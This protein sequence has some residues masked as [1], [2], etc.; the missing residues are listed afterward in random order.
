MPTLW[1][2]LPTPAA[3]LLRSTQPISA[4]S[5]RNLD[6]ARCF[7]VTIEDARALA[8]ILSDAGFDDPRAEDTALYSTDTDDVTVEYQLIL[9]DGFITVPIGG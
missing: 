6:G 7:D 8:A 1:P 9:P 4:D 2:S 5:S 3:D